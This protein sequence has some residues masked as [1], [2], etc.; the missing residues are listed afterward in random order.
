VRLLVPLL[1]FNQGDE[2]AYFILM[3]ATVAVAGLLRRR[4]GLAPQGLDVGGDRDGLDVFEVLIP[5]ALDPAQKLLDRAVIDGSRV[6][7]ADRDRKK[8]EEL[9]AG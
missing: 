2:T 5:G 3:L 7:V 1:E 9:I 6:S 4:S 8:L